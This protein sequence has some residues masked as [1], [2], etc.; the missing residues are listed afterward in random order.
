MTCME[1]VGSLSGNGGGCSVVV[2]KVVCCFP[3]LTCVWTRCV[4][5]VIRTNIY[6]ASLV[7]S[8]EF[9]D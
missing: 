3:H 1:M 5:T 2:K 6:G 8:A 7:V 9:M 4:E